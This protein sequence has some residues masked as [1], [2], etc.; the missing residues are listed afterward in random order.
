MNHKPFPVSIFK[1]GR[2]EMIK[3]SMLLP[4]ERNPS[5]PSS[6]ERHEKLTRKT[7]TYTECSRVDLTALRPLLSLHVRDE[8]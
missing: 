1:D 8:R 3:E 2:T 4:F 6:D 7:D 5:S